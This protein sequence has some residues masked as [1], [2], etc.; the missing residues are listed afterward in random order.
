VSIVALAIVALFTSWWVLIAVYF[1]WFHS[2]Y[3][4]CTS[5]TVYH[6]TNRQLRGPQHLHAIESPGKIRYPHVPTIANQFQLLRGESAMKFYYVDDTNDDASSIASSIASNNIG[7][8]GT[9]NN[10]SGQHRN[11]NTQQQSSG[12]HG[13]CGNCGVHILRAPSRSSDALE[14]NANCLEDGKTK[15]VYR[16]IFS[17]ASSLTNSEHLTG[18]GSGLARQSTSNTSLSIERG[19]DSTDAMGTQQRSNAIETVDENEAFLGGSARFWEN[20]DD[21]P[22]PPESYADK[23]MS[24]STN[25][26]DSYHDTQPLTQS[27]AESDDYSMGS[28]SITAA[29][30]LHL[31]PYSSVSVASGGGASI[32]NRMGMPPL[33]PSSGSVKTLPPRFAEQHRSTMMGGYGTSTNRSVGAGVG[34]SNWSIAS[35][36]SNDLDGDIGSSTVSP[37]T[38]NQMKYYMSRH[39]SRKE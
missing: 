23:F 37:K 21:R 32:Q 3:W 29:S 8:E 20:L 2:F 5:N 25:E 16:K 1:H 14:I 6:T 35:M 10:N 33:L 13:F 12:A 28:S 27:V 26:S 24:A 15:F 38:M 19:V 34:G 4:F 31:A 7:R 30:T 39:M 22:A 11:S 36:E 17:S 18:N 9:H